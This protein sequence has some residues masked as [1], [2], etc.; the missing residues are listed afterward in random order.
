MPAGRTPRTRTD[1]GPL[2]APALP[3]PPASTVLVG[4]VGELF[5]GDMDVG[6]RVVERLAHERLP[7]GVV[8]ED[9]HYGAIAVSQLLE[10]L[11]PAALV[12]VGAKRRGRRAGT[13]ERRRIGEVDLDVATVQASVGDAAVGYVDLDLVLDVTW[14]FGTLPSD[15]VVLEVEPAD[16]GPGEELSAVGREAVD[17]LVERVRDE[18][19][20]R[21]RP[22]ARDA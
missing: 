17:E 12:L 7:A 18:V 19:Q 2:T 22:R 6:R 13:I 9:M 14:G 20:Q 1:P 4:G 5:Q 15:T 10:D 16:V 21:V 11:V 3:A 8:L